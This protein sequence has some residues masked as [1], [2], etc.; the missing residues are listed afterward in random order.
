MALKIKAARG[1]LWSL[2]EYGGGEGIS[3][4]VFLALARLLT[5]DSFGIVALAGVFVA[6][7]Q[8]FLVQGFMDAV[9]QREELRADHL[10][11][12]FWSNQ[13]IAG[14]FFL[15]TQVAAGPAA[16]AFGKPFLEDVLRWLSLVFIST[17]L[18]SIHQAVLKRELRFAAFAVR[19]IIGVTTG[20]IVGIAMAMMGCGVWSL[21]GQQLANGAAS[22]VVMWST[23]DWRP[24]RRF[25]VAA[26]DDM[27]RFAA[28]VIGSNL[29]GFL[30]RKL[31]VL[32]VGFFLDPRQLGY[33]YLVQRLLTT[34]GLITL[35]AV[36]SIVMPVLSRLQGEPARFRQMY[37]TTV[38]IVHAVYLPAVVGLGAVGSVL[39][40]FVF[41]EQWRPAVPLVEIMCLG[42]FTQA[43][44]CF[45]G[46]ALWAAG[47]P[48]AYL[49][50]S[51]VQVA[52][53][54]AVFLPAT[55][56]GVNGVAA[57]Y[58]AVTVLIIP[59]HLYV[60][61]RHAGVDPIDLL[62]RC[63]P[64]AVAGLALILA[65]EAAELRLID[66]WPPL[67]QSMA[68]PLIG[69]A[70]YILT[71]TVAAPA[72]VREVL[73]LLVAALDRRGATPPPERAAA[74]GTAS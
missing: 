3:L 7:V 45:S 61:Q 65:V 56:L 57:A 28:H 26:F 54:A 37:S 30:Y 68:L 38:Q 13:A 53:T 69:A 2:L 36:Q 58:T 63:L 25:S 24:R 42:G 8:V 34:T 18:I 74:G 4:I 39:I 60:L 23:S 71:L 12:A 9:I 43:L 48:Q 20:G 40:P 15:L 59:F 73:E 32:L 21:V 6:F 47:R 64:S 50:L 41:G 17:A 10:D 55:Q 31:D 1:V 14:G 5:P 70:A 11:T 27:G 22:V 46:P 72:L 33:Y 52:L 44:T 62:K 19:A 66:D 29:V 35:S 67:L 16:A 49:R 51:V